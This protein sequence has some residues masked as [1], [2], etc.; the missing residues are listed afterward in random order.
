MKW[1]YKKLSE[2]EN[3]AVYSYVIKKDD[4]DP[5]KIL[6]D[7]KTRETNVVKKASS[8]VSVGYDWVGS[9]FIHVIDGGFPDERLVTI[10]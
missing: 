2:D 5:G 9:S 7:K 8:D 10:G 1:H 6:Y 4:K 3:T